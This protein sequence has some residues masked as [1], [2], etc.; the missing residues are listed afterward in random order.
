M[1]MRAPG[2][3]PPF[4]AD[5][6]QTVIPIT[7]QSDGSVSF[8]QGW[9]PDYQKDQT[10]EPTAKP[11]DRASTNYL[12]YALSQLINRWQTETFPEFIDAAGNG[13]TPYPYSRGT[14]VRFGSG[15]NNLRM[16]MVDNNTATPGG[17]DTG[18]WINPFTRLANAVM[19]SAGTLDDQTVG[20]LLNLAG[21]GTVPNIPA[22]STSTAIANAAFVTNGA[23][24]QSNPTVS[25]P[26]TSS[27]LRLPQWLSTGAT[28]RFM[29]AWG[30][31]VV[32]ANPS[33]SVGTR[34]I[35]FPLAFAG[36]PNVFVTASGQPNNAG[37]G[38]IAAYNQATSGFSCVLDANATAAS[39]G[40]NVLANN[41]PFNW[42][43]IGVESGPISR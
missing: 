12:M 40:G 18:Q 14:I 28:R 35:T 38:T 1:P 42:F 24:S 17:S 37:L 5:G 43:A 19:T 29:I 9:G 26:S 11:I 6:D 34:V 33:A 3:L 15:L 30:S 10:T 20:G 41:V 22:N 23:S 2:L 8:Q 36:V 4:A 13:G 32:P 7:T 39:P 16:S 31:G 25:Q 21:G 27:Y